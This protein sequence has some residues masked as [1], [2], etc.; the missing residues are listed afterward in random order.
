MLTGNERR[1]EILD[2]LSASDKPVSGSALAKRFSVS[3]QVVVQDIALLRA[4]GHQILSAARGYVLVK[5]ETRRTRVFKVLDVRR[6]EE[7]ISGGK[8]L[9]LSNATSGYHY[10]TV[11]ADSEQVLDIIQSELEKRGYLA[12]LQDYEPVNFWKS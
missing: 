10:H 6:Y 1:R 8:S 9:P 11:S 4:E 12:K 2:C 5:P 3:R 7:E